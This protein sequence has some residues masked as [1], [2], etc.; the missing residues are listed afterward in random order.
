MKMNFYYTEQEHMLIYLVCKIFLKITEN[1]RRL[2]NSM[3]P[4][5]WNYSI[6]GSFTY[7]FI[8][9]YVLNLFNPLSTLKSE[10]TDNAFQE[11]VGF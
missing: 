1:C 5:H 8:F 3:S 7:A 11:L 10:Y 9:L 6:S 2:N 4:N